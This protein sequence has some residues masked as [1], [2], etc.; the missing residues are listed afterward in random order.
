MVAAVLRRVLRALL[1]PTFRAGRPI[2]QQRVLLE[3]I[4]AYL[5]GPAALRLPLFAF[6]RARAHALAGESEAAFRALDEAYERGFRT[7]WALDLRPQ[8]LL[9][10]DPIEC[11]DCNN[12]MSECPVEAIFQESDVPKEW[13]S[14]I[15]L[16]REMSQKT[17]S[18]YTKKTPLK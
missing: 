3:R 5:D 7:T 16:N 10:I 9:Y 12:C 4:A 14:F 1:L 13:E 6:Q 15:E 18:I 11:V 8:S 17:P 2:T